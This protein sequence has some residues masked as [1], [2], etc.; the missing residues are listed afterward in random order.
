[1]V[2]LVPVMLVGGGIAYVA[3]KG[4]APAAPGPTTQIAPMS[5]STIGQQIQPIAGVMVAPPPKKN[6]ASAVRRAQVVGSL[7][8]TSPATSYGGST[9]DPELKKKLDAI[10]AAARAQFDKLDAAGKQAAA[11]ELN[12]ALKLDPP[13]KG[14]EDWA[15]VAA[16][17]GGAAGAAAGGALCGPICA[18][19]G[20]LAGAYL[21]TEL[22]ELVARNWDDLKGW[23]SSQWGSVEEFA[24]DAY[25]FIGGLNPF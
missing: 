10:E 22:A 24:S 16:V 6:L 13:L 12:K 4:A 21:G 11:D 7:V 25:D 14:N 20:A 23:L 19:V 17:T 2:G 5:G 3:T 15:T 1:M 8:Q 9:V 18:K